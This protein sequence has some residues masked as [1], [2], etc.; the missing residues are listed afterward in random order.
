MAKCMVHPSLV[1]KLHDMYFVKFHG[2]SVLRSELKGG[3]MTM[4]IK[5]TDRLGVC[6]NDAQP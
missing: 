5:I 1:C 6:F 2:R 4:V 3:K